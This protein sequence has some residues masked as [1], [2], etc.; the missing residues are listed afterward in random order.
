[1]EAR[2]Q[3]LKEREAKVAGLL[4]EQSTGIK[5][6]VKWVGEANSTLDILGLSPIQVA[7]AHSSLGAI[8]PVLDSTAERL[9]HLES[10]VVGLVETEG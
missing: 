9:Q 5:W 7:E 8:L 2:T 3:D 4:A 1:M 10:T 6:V